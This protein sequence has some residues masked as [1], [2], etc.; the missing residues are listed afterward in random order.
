MAD[1]KTHTILGTGVGIGL[2]CLALTGNFIT[3][4]GSVLAVFLSAVASA[5]P[6]IDSDSGSPRKFALSALEILCPAILMVSFTNDFSLE[7]LLLSG[8]A[9]FFVIRYPLGFL[10]DKSTKHRGAWHSIPMALIGSMIVYLVFYRSAF[11]SRIFFALIF[12]VCFLSH[13]ILDEICSLKYFGLSVKKSFGTALKFSGSTRIQTV[14]M[15]I[16]IVILSC[17]CI[18]DIAGGK[19]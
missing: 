11:S 18:F 8:I 19:Q 17:I 15:Y 5:L 10:I 7:N 12:F 2:S 14:F 4:S 9:V 3:L 13:L 6:D 16:V 1:F